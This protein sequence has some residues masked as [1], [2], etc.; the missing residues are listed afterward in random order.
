MSSN[1]RIQRICEHC[2]KEFIAK[3]TVTKYCSH[4][5]N[6]AAYKKKIKGRKV[7]ASNKETFLLKTQPFQELNAKEYL[8][9][10]EASTLLNCSIRTTY[11]LIENNTL[12]AVNLA[13]RLTRIKKTELD[14]I[15]SY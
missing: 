3:T 11:R 4:N 9:V 12:K 1:I 6:R 13:N 8:T 7:E 15:L 5:C 2:Q 14:K 10:K